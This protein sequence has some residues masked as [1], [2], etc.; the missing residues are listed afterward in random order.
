MI[1]GPL[2]CAVAAAFLLLAGCSMFDDRNEAQIGYDYFKAGDDGHAVIHLETAYHAKPDDP[3]LQY[4]LAAA[5]ARVG[6]FADAKTYYGKV[7][8]S[9]KDVPADDGSGKT[10]A[11]LAQ[12][13]LD[14]LPK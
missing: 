13:H 7:L 10:L 14:Q 9:G 1:H 3:V 5:Y 8:A 2:R 11:E 4:D 12:S 6:R